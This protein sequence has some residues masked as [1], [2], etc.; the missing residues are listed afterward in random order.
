M[1]QAR[2]GELDRATIELAQRGDTNAFARIVQRYQTPVYNLAYRMLGD[3]AEAEDAAQETFLRAYAQLKRYR[4]DQRFASWLLSIAAHYCI[5]RLRRRKFQWLSL[6]EE[7]AEETFPSP[8]AGPEEQAFDHERTAEVQQLVQ[9]LNPQSRAIVV[10]K[11]WS[12]MDLQEIARVT[13]ETV[14]AVKVK[15]FRARRAMARQLQRQTGPA[16]PVAHRLEKA[17]GQVR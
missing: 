4:T 16:G 9:S 11:Y 1:E 14:G 10:M 3:P 8:G 17:V 7:S 15:L 12:D 5:D 2:T 13:G 6:D